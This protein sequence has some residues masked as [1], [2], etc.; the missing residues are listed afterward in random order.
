MVGTNEKQTDMGDAEN[1]AASEKTPVDASI[2]ENE[3]IPMI[4]K[5]P[6]N[7]KSPMNEKIPVNEK[8]PMK[9]ITTGNE[10][11]TLVTKHKD[12]DALKEINSN[13]K[14]KMSKPQCDN[15]KEPVVDEQ[16]KSTDKLKNCSV[17]MVRIT[18][19]KHMNSGNDIKDEKNSTSSVTKCSVKVAKLDKNS[20][21]QFTSIRDIVV[22]GAVKRSTRKGNKEV[23]DE[24]VHPKK[25]KQV[26]TVGTTSTIKLVPARTLKSP[27]TVKPAIASTLK[28]PKTEKKRKNQKKMGK[29]G[30]HE[31]KV[32]KTCSI[33]VKKMSNNIVRM[34]HIPGKGVFKKNKYS[35]ATKEQLLK[36]NN[37]KNDAIKNCQIKLKKL[38]DGI[39]MHSKR[40]NATKPCIVS[41]QKLSSATGKDKAKRKSTTVSE[42]M[43][44][45]DRKLNRCLRQGTRRSYVY[46]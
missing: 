2:T 33:K 45:R 36:T 16:S 46:F 25:I 1:A 28:S 19:S 41:I 32:I 39:E 15:I 8:I 42:S 3:K 14:F 5:I 13:D 18:E 22:N 26:K 44:G 34:K 27:K 43:Q 30:I 6:V 38:S 29:M 35:T 10:D 21:S 4:E 12:D 9:Q 23:N 37:V 20:I 40:N 7:E 11:T 24:N 17:K 31:H